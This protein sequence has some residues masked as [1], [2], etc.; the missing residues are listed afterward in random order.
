MKVDLYAKPDPKSAMKAIT[1]GRLMGSLVGA[2]AVGAAEGE[3]APRPCALSVDPSE[4]CHNYIGHDC[5]GHN[6]IG[7]NYVGR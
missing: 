6:Y 2:G 5:L 3:A 7:H 4:R 1:A